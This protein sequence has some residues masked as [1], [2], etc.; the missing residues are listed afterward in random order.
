MLCAALAGGT[1]LAATR[2]LTPQWASQADLPAHH[3]SVKLGDRTVDVIVKSA[4]ESAVPLMRETVERSLTRFEEWFGPL[5]ATQLTVVD[6]PWNVDGPGASYPSIVATRA[7]LFRP[8]RDLVAERALIAGVARQFWFAGHDDPDAWFREGLAIYT[9]TRGIH[10]IL[11]GRNF[12]APR[13]FGDFVPFPIRSLML[14]PNMP[15]TR[16]LLRGFDDILQPAEA[17][18]RFASAATG[19]PSRRADSA[20]RTLERAIGWPAMQQALSETRSRTAGAVTPEVLMSVVAEQRGVT[21]DWF[22]RDVV[23]GNEPID[24][25]VERLRVEGARTIVTVRR[26][27][28]GVF[29]GTDQPRSSGAA[30]SLPVLVRFIDGSETRGYVDGRDAST[31][32]VFE[33]A[34]PAALVMI[35]PDETVLMDADRSNNTRLL[36]KVPVQ[37]TGLRLMMNWMMWLQNAML[38]ATAIA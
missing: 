17:P 4:Q 26:Q 14:S 30:R 20:L 35:D 2:E 27:G 12:A 34:V 28:A 22:R 18:W 13:F 10:A 38:T 16:P 32:L 19:T 11:E 3:A 15:G 23:R 9:A 24:Y 37:R 31:E 8:V 36:G 7:R 29:A 6:L 25:A 5:D 21:M 33:S 1:V